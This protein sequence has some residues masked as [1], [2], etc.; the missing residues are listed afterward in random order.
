M[1]V[2]NCRE[3]GENLQKIVRRLMANDNLVNLLY[4]TDKDPLNHPFL[5]EEQKRKEIYEKLIKV[6][7]RT[8]SKEDARSM[9]TIRVVSGSKIGANTEFQ[10]VKICIEVFV[11]MTQWFIK[12]T[13]LRPFAILGEIEESL[14]GKVINGLGSIKGGDF[15]LNY[16]TEEMG[17]YEQTF[18]VTSYE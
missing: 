2:R 12:D 14:Q 16:L 10:N 18:W 13:N 5:T 8:G 9:I 7:P 4:Y 1:A 11:P 15:I 6:I 3:I 17:A